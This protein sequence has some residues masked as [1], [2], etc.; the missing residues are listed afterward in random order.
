M[1][2]ASPKHDA[3]RLDRPP[4]LTELVT[5]RLRDWIVTGEAMSDSRKSAGQFQM[6]SYSQPS[7]NPAVCGRIS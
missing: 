5:A 6:A 1:T 3:P 7:G 4:S 2:D